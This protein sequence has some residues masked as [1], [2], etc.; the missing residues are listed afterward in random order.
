MTK[1]TLCNELIDIP[2]IWLCAQ[3]HLQIMLMVEELKR[4]S[5]PNECSMCLIFAHASCISGNQETA[6]ISKLFISSFTSTPKESWLMHS[7][8]S[9][10][11]IQSNCFGFLWFFFF[12]WIFFSW[13]NSR[14][15]K[16]KISCQCHLNHNS[17]KF[18]PLNREAY[19]SNTDKMSVE[20]L[21]EVE[22][23]E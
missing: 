23:F 1:P 20:L 5:V 13:F 4:C 19:L 16:E 22:R 8:I 7:F 15:K 11:D 3:P 9:W 2:G 6:T 12:L 18:T 17:Y 14:G 10:T 21:T